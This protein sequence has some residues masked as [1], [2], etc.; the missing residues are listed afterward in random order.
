MWA[1]E[2]GKTQKGTG[3][4]QSY[5]IR[6]HTNAKLLPLK[7]LQSGFEIASILPSTIQPQKTG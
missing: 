1:F 7:F 4:K 3:T 5:S 2:V 6:S